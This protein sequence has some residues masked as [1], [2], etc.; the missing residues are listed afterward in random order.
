MHSRASSIL[1]QA[2]SALIRCP[3]AFQAIAGVATTNNTAIRKSSRRRA[4]VCGEGLAVKA[5]VFLRRGIFQGFEM[6]EHRRMGQCMAKFTLQFFSHSVALSDRPLSRDQNM[7]RNE[8]A[9]AGLTGTHGVKIDALPT[10][11]LEDREYLGLFSWRQAGIH[12]AGS[13]A[14]QQAPARIHDVAGKQ[15]GE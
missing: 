10:V 8:T 14:L 12:Q 6:G 11:R 13:R 5:D 7:Q 2:S 15:Q 3:A 4:L 9:C 1:S